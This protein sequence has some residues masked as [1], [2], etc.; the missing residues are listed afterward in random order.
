MEP[1]KSLLKE[2][3]NDG[4]VVVLIGVFAMF[5]RLLADKT[6]LNVAEQFK[7][8]TTAAI[9]SGIAW[10][11]IDSG[12]ILATNDISSLIKAII[13]GIIGVISPEILGGIVRIGKIFEKNPEKF[14]K[15]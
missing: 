3:M 10:A 9:L 5:S 2:F 4:W 1:E 8:I 15:K 12:F 6:D 11:I 7:R 13:Y 14:I